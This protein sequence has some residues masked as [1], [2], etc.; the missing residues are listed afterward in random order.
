MIAIDSKQI[1]IVGLRIYQIFIRY[2]IYPCGRICF[3]KS[4]I[5]FQISINLK[6]KLYV[7]RKKKIFKNYNKLFRMIKLKILNHL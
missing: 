5:W 6:V 1:T 2:Q 7:I 4:I 3:L